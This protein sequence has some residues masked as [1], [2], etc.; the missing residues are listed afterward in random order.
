M[1]VRPS[2]TGPLAPLLNPDFRLLLTGF[3]I[4]QMLMPLQFITQILWVQHYA[5]KDIWLILVAFIATS[6]G[7]GAL[8][9]GLYGGALADRFDRRKLLIT[10]QVL[11]VLSTVVIA[12]LMYFSVGGIVGF[13]VFFALT[14][15]T[16]GLQSIDA[17]TRLAIVPDVLGTGLAPAGM[18]LNQVAGQ[19]A[20]PVAMMATGLIIEAFGFS[21]A[22][23]FS[24]LGHVIAI[25]CITLMAYKSS[26]TIE[27][28][29]NMA[30]GGHTKISS[31]VCPTPAT[32][33]FC[34]G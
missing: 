24:A 22:Y 29:K 1:N 18:S 17:P 25:V 23:L 5:P 8:L 16:S 32:T 21:G 11:Q 26:H 14:F 34:C 9:F 7:L 3:A 6:R 28:G 10:I 27:E 15:L 2:A 31:L 20:M 13:A 19:V 33:P 12:A 4:G 30:C